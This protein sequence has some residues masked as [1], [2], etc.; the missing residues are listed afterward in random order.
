MLPKTDVG[1]TVNL[2]AAA[3]DRETPQRVSTRMAECNTQPF[4][5]NNQLNQYSRENYFPLTTVV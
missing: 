4:P 1:L 3:C 5:V 2:R